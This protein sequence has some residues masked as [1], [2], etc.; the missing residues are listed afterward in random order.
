MGF[1]GYIWLT[2][3]PYFFLSRERRHWGLRADCIYY[4]KLVPARNIYVRWRHDLLSFSIASAEISHKSNP[5][6]PHLSTVF[7]LYAYFLIFPNFRNGSKPVLIWRLKSSAQD[8]PFPSS[9]PQSSR[10]PS[11]WPRQSSVSATKLFWI[12]YPD[13][14][15]KDNVA[16]YCP[17]Q[18]VVLL[19]R[20]RAYQQTGFIP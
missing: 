12:T 17:I 10:L 19:T 7:L 20:L 4:A 6:R 3:P 18:L 9:S 15:C 2:I 1:L 14:I 16:Y 11:L 8:F 5:R 13:T